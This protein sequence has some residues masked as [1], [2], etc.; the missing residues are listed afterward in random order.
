MSRSNQN[1]TAIGS[2]DELAEALC[3][4]NAAPLAH[5][6]PVKYSILQD[7]VKARCAD[8]GLPWNG[9]V[10]VNVDELPT[11]G[12]EAPD[13][14]EVFLVLSHDAER[15][16]IGNGSISEAHLIGRNAWESHC[17][18]AQAEMIASLFESGI[19]EA[20]GEWRRSLEDDLSGPS[21]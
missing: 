14:A 16:L 13:P 2:L 4:I 9:G 5:G 8:F 20:L 19:P 7:A 10:G 15:Y 17:E 1:E 21:P 6:A 3:E 12:G 11:F 18:R